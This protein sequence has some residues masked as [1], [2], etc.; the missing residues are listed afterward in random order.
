LDLIE[1]IIAHKK[2]KK[3]TQKTSRQGKCIIFSSRIKGKLLTR[4]KT[5]IKWLNYDQTEV[6]I[7]GKIKKYIANK[8]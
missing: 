5:I 4:V 6:I 1:V 8:K 3:K 7:T 2:R